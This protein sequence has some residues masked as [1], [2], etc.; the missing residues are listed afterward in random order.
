MLQNAKLLCKEMDSS[1]SGYS[2]EL[3]RSIK[4]TLKLEN[5][6]NFN[7]APLEVQ[8]ALMDTYLK[9]LSPGFQDNSAGATAAISVGQGIF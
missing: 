6:F 8:R 7:A 4:T 5:D 1:G 2:A 3:V 9:C